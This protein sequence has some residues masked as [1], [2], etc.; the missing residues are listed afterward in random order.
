M[1]AIKRAVGDRSLRRLNNFI[2]YHA[3]ANFR[4]LIV[5]QGNQRLT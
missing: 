3:A 2:A 5:A 4:Y 1:P